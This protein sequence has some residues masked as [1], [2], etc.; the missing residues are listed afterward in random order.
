MVP[1][2]YFKNDL[3]DTSLKARLSI[4]TTFDS[5]YYSWETPFNA[6]MTLHVPTLSQKIT[7]SGRNLKEFRI[8]NNMVP[9]CFLKWL[10]S[11]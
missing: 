11:N 6:L 8:N 2:N 7:E 3:A 1:E 9:N 10:Y 5:R 4:D